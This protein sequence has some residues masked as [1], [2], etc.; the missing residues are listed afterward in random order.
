MGDWRGKRAIHDQQL[1]HEVH[2]RIGS[3]AY[4]STCLCYLIDGGV[5]LE[6]ITKCTPL[7][8]IRLQLLEE[9]FSGSTTPRTSVLVSCVLGLKIQHQEGGGGG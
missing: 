7:Y 9:W 2:T 8:Q 1:Q 6:N 3:S 5:G 4:I